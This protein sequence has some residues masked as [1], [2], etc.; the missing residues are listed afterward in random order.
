MISGGATEAAQAPIQ[1]RKIIDGGITYYFFDVDG[2]G[3]F[4]GQ[5]ARK[6]RLEMIAEGGEQYVLLRSV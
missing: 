2:S 5:G 1:A 6:F 4:L 3:G